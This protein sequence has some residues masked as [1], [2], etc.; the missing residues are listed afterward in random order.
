MARKMAVLAFLALLW[1]F[2]TFAAAP[3]VYADLPEVKAIE[4]YLK[5][6]GTFKARFTQT[7]NDGARVGGDF[8]LK[9]PGRMRFQYDPPMTDFI[10]ADGIFVHYYDGS[11]QHSSNTLIG[12]SLA[13]FFLRKDLTIPGEDLT[14]AGLRRAGGQ[15]WLTLAQRRDPAA[16]SLTLVF[17]EK[18]MTL[19]KWVILDPQGAKTTVELSEIES[20][21]PLDSELFKYYNPRRSQKGLN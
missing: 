8:Y 9:R 12:Q 3:R 18:P 6:L 16:G 7:A 1:P 17:A 19:K 15:L 4:S 13:D 14:I 10:V 5:N 20:G 21:L 11:L 2:Q